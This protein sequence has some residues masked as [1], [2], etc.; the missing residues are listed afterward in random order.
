MLHLQTSNQSPEAFHCGIM[1]VIATYIDWRELSN[2]NGVGFC[3]NLLAVDGIVS[4]Y[5]KLVDVS[6]NTFVAILVS[7]VVGAVVA[8]LAGASFDVVKSTVEGNSAAEGAVDI[9]R[10]VYDFGSTI[11]DL[12]EYGKILA[13]V[14][15]AIAGAIGAIVVLLKKLNLID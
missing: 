9:G 12:Y 6:L 1:P 11:Q 5:S 10:T 3:K 13:P 8:A 7:I 15:P 4:A 2:L 14:G